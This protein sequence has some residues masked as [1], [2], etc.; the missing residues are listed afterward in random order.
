VST[1]QLGENSNRPE[2]N[3]TEALAP[4]A[5][6]T[7]LDRQNYAQD[8]QLSIRGFG[9]RSTFGVRS[10]R[11]YADG[12]PASMPDGQGQLSNFNLMGGDRLQVMR[13]PFSALYGNSSGGVVQ[14]W[15]KSGEVGDPTR[16]RATYGS[17]DARSL[18]AQTLGRVGAV[19]YN[20]AISRFETDGY[21]DH[22]AARR[23]ALNARVGFDLGERRSLSLVLNYLDLPEAQDPLG[24]TRTQ[25]NVDPQQVDG[26]ATQFNTRKSVTQLQGGLVFEQKLATS[27]VLRVMAYTG[28]R[29][30]T[31][32]LAIPTGPQANALHSGGVIELDN[33][34]RG[35][36]LRWS[37]QGN[38]A[39]RPLEVT[40]GANAD[41]QKQLRLGFENFVGTALGVRGRLRRDESNRVGNVDQ[42]A[43]VW[44]ELAPR[45]SMLAGLRHS[46]VTFRS[47]DRY[48]VGTNGNDSG[49]KTYTDTTP[50]AGVIFHPFES[51]RLYVSA[52][53]GFETPTFNELSYRADAGAGL[54]FNLR[55]ATSDNYE[56]GLKWRGSAGL[57][58]DTA[59]FR[60]NTRDELA[61]ARNSGGRSSFRNINNARR[62]GF[63]LTVG[64]PIASQ[65]RAEL[66]YTYVDAR[67]LSAYSICTVTPCITPNFT[68]PAGSRIPGVARH[69]A[70]ASLQWSPGQWTAAIE[71]AGI[72]QLIA[73]DRGSEA[74][75]GYALLHAEVGRNWKLGNSAL[76]GFA[77]IENILDKA[78][79]GSVIVN[80]G[81][82]RYYESGTDR[83]LLVGAQ[84]RWR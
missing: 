56:L 48:I 22:S 28:N 55:P 27:Q 21:R 43:Q 46:E 63:E 73:N 24:I 75:P 14:I 13:G 54:A 23:D 72:S 84:W 5:G 58:L 12:I 77:R 53:Q 60:A 16:L 51:L 81:N 69:Q 3:V 4:L 36:D 66:A 29:D 62:E 20:L 59:L 78:Y 18:G 49:D 42:F 50:V 38:I 45:W 37:W 67:F 74:A 83:S 70:H 6:I 35:V 71:A 2:I 25:W 64:M 1:V 9:A 76:R 41:E 79:I 44:W 30:V 7:A 47:R 68:V 11:L 33:T 26:V 17:N 40:I 82:Q 65:W 32:F 34:F 61:L 31:Q 52:G 8:T 10:L 19:D 80:E 39:S 57:E 15:S